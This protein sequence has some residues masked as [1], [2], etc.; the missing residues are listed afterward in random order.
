MSLCPQFILTLIS[1][2]NK[3]FKPFLCFRFSQNV[4]YNTL[5]ENMQ[6]LALHF[7]I[8]RVLYNVIQLVYKNICWK[9]VGVLNWYWTD[10]KLIFA[11]TC[12]VKIFLIFAGRCWI[13]ILRSFVAYRCRIWMSTHVSCAASTSKVRTNVVTIPDFAM[14]YISRYMGHDAIRIAILVYRVNQC[15]YLQFVYN[16]NWMSMTMLINNLWRSEWFQLNKHN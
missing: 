9:F 6:R 16:Y 8:L 13:L 7:I 3:I 2:G 15:L 14:R 1:R 10:T 11:D 4:V 12:F 5:I